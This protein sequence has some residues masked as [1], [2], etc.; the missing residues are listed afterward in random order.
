VRTCMPKLI[1]LAL[2]M[3]AASK[4][5]KNRNFWYKFA[6]KGKFSG[7]EKKLTDMTDRRTDGRTDRHGTTA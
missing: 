7:P 5:A 2:K 3:W 6:P 1:V 4:I